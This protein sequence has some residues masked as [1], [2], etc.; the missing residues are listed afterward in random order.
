VFELG[1]MCGRGKLAFAYSNTAADHFSRTSDYYG[2]MA[3]VW[4]DGHL[5]GPDGMLLEDFDMAENLMLDGGVES[6]GGKVIVR[7]VPPERL[8]TDTAAFE[9]CLRLLVAAGSRPVFP[10]PLAAPE[11]RGGPFP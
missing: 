7:D 9:E 3:T 5:R 6:R 10:P 1:F 4:A 11:N 2:G 8:N